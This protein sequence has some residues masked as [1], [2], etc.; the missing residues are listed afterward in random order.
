MKDPIKLLEIKNFKTIKQLKF[1]CKRINLFIGKPNVGKSNILE[2]I[3]LLG[4]SYSSQHGDKHKYLSEFIRYNRIE[5][6]FYDKQTSN[7]ILINS[8]IGNCIINNQ[9]YSDSYT[10]L[11]FNDIKIIN[12]IQD[13]NYKNLPD[14]FVKDW[15]NLTLHQVKL[16][17]F[18][19]NI[20]ADGRLISSHFDI[21]RWHNPIKKYDF[22]KNE[23]IDNRFH[24][25]LT[26]PNG[27]NQ[28]AVLNNNKTL[29]KEISGFFK[30]YKLDFVLKSDES[31]FALQ[32]KIDG[33]IYSYEYNLI[34]DTM[35][36]IIFYLLAISSNKE[37]ILI[38]EEPETHSFPLYTKKFAK[39]IAEST[40]NQY[41]I[42]THSP[43]ILN[44]LIENVAP[45]DLNIFITK[46]E[47]YQTKVELLSQKEIED[48]LNYG[49]DIF[50]S[51]RLN[52]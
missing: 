8:N 52:N 25:F 41:F 36:R 13:N 50:F 34:A 1:D 49:N 40:S 39:K 20:H 42:A 5:D 23:R 22:K 30:E 3:S 45:E 19:M 4:G 46:Y 31:K 37:S 35:Q 17:N 7:D 11:L 14:N 44:T 48:M 27:D 32:K 2:A 21:I 51:P 24:M 18:G 29:F 47:K 12:N 15:N 43:F 10:F 6:L 9:Y 28:Y 33:V 38:F 16:P 26:P